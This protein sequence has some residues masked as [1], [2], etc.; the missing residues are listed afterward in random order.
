MVKR[1]FFSAMYPKSNLLNHEIDT[2]GLFGSQEHIRTCTIPS[3]LEL[4]PQLIYIPL[5][6]VFNYCQVRFLLCFV[7]TFSTNY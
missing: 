1:F 6:V 5:T 7:K 4:N 2:L 3:V